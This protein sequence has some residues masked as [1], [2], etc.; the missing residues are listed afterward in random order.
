[1]DFLESELRFKFQKKFGGTFYLTIPDK[2]LVYDNDE[3]IYVVDN[4]KASEMAEESIKMNQNLFLLNNTLS[5]NNKI[6]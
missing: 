3:D 4:N 5:L 1:M 2:I 6:V